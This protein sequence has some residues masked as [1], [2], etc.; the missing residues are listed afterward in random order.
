V[1]LRVEVRALR[2]RRV[3]VYHPHV[4]EVVVR[5]GAAPLGVSGGGILEGPVHGEL[6]QIAPRVLPPRREGE[7]E[8]VRVSTL[9]LVVGVSGGSVRSVRV[10]V[11]CL[12]G[13]GATR[14]LR[15]RLTLTHLTHPTHPTHPNSPDSP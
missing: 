6:Q 11:G 5:Q 14:Y 9:S 13:E 8:R 12:C 1:Q 4:V 10:R 7:V 2:A 15:T 3:G